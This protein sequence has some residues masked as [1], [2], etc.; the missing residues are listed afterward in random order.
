MI[1]FHAVMLDETHCEFGVDLE[2][3]SREAAYDKLRDDYP[4]S[5]CVQ[6]EDEAQSQEREQRTYHQ[7]MRY[8]DDPLLDD[9]DY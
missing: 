7:A 9:F 3:A 2:A 6:L 8:L 5:R 1:R 4:E